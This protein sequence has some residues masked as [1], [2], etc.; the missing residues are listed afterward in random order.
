MKDEGR[1][2]PTCRSFTKPRQSKLLACTNTTDITKLSP[3]ALT[4]GNTE[5]EGV[6]GGGEPWLSNKAFKM[7]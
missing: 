2:E 3:A 1:P 4:A 5:M 6:R 7:I